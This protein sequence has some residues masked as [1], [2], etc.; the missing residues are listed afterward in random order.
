MALSFKKTARK[1]RTPFYC[2]SAMAVGCLIGSPLSAEENDRD[3]LAVSKAATTIQTAQFRFSPMPSAQTAIPQVQVP[4]PSS[5]LMPAPERVVAGGYLPAVKHSLAPVFTEPS[6][7]VTK[8]NGTIGLNSFG[9]AEVRAE[10]QTLDPSVNVANGQFKRMPLTQDV[11]SENARVFPKYVAAKVRNGVHQLIAI[12]IEDFE[13]SVVTTWGRRL[14]TATS[15]DGRYVRV[16]IPTRVSQRMAMIVDRQSGTMKFEGDDSLREN[17]HQLMES[18]DCGPE[19]TRLGAVRKTILVDANL[20]ELKT[21]QQ[22]A[23]LMGLTQDITQ[24]EQGGQEDITKPETTIT[25]PPGTTLPQNMNQDV[26]DNVKDEVKIIQDPD[27]GIITLIGSEADLAI[28]RKVIEEISAKSKS[29]QALVERISLE[30]LQSGQIAEQVQEIYDASYAPSTGAAKIQALD[31]PNALVVVGQP[32]GIKAIQ[33]LIA[34]MDV[35]GSMDELGGF[36]AIPLK[37]LSASDAKIRLDSYFNQANTGQGTQ[38]ASTP[39]TIIAD[40]RSNSIIVKGPKEVIT[41]AIQVL[42]TIDV[43]EVDGKTNTVKVFPLRNTLA[44]EMAIVLQDAISGQQP[45]AGQGYNP[46]QQAQQ[47]QQNANQQ[48]QPNQ[49]SLGAAQL[50]LRTIDEKGKEIKS[51]I[52]FDVRVTADRNSNSLVVTGPAESMELIGALIEKLDRI[53]DAETQIKVFEIVNGDAESLLTMLENL[54]GGDTAQQGGQNGTSNLSQLPLQGLSATEGS[55][56]IN[57]RFSSDARTN[58]IIASGP[59]GDLQVVEDLLNRLDTRDVTDRK[60]RVYRLSNAPARDVVEAIN[61]YLGSRNDIVA[62]DPRTGGAFIQADRS[63]VVVEETVSNSVIVSATPSQRAEIEE[64]IRGLDR[65][66]P[67]VKVKCLIAEVDLGQTEEF[68]ID[69]GIQDSLI[70]DRGTSIGADGSI[71]GIG[72][73]FNTSPLPVANLIGAFPETMAGQ[74]VSNLATGTVNSKLGYGGL[75]LS[76]GNE[77]INILMR[78][79]KDKSSTRILSRPQITTVENLQGRVQIG[80]SVARIAGTT[81]TNGLSQQNIEFEDVGVILEVTPRVSPDGMIVMAV[82]A[83]K[84][85]V[86]PDSE[87]IV[88]GY[89]EAGVNSTPQPIVSP[90]IEETVAQ[91][92]LMARSGQTVVFSGLITEE[93]QH[94]KRGAPILSDLPWIGPL[95]SFESDIAKRTELLI[96]MTPYLITDDQDLSAQNQD[97]MDRMHWCLCDVAE[98][99]G[100]T[101][102]KGMEGTE[103]GIETIYPDADPSGMKGSP[104]YKVISANDS[105]VGNRLT[106]GSATSRSEPRSSSNQNVL[107]SELNR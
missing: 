11:E 58:T 26:Q 80:A 84:S 83:T 6:V 67:M 18:I 41:Q 100:N 53:P 22:A 48:I 107:S 62:D 72:F 38:L 106:P 54:F 27:T 40:F 79:L 28:V 71:G 7:P 2:F 13:T 10:P 24:P 49:S 87:G 45:N 89:S 16:E 69:I 12:S 77:S 96:I 50:S 98:V 35:V 63:V 39:I 90:N 66:P 74:A 31:S 88:I 19:V 47:N 86:G 36:Q 64:L 30:Y 101:D 17:W 91:T 4:M 81:V 1:F 105:E 37:Y 55:T 5:G 42:K 23:F 65:R 95:F 46:N 60:P 51:G 82:N 32:A 52:M 70:F 3:K 97:E 92:T 76:G 93:K 29:R 34:S 25:L 103:A 68:G 14:G 33:Q 20:A 59:A 21:V 43:A 75:V 85:S 78:A 61:S 56:L 94:V 73:P 44:E 102:Y 15:P 99:Y 8:S 104:L 57:L 9:V